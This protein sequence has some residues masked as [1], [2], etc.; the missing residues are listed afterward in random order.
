MNIVAWL[1][2]GLVAGGLAKFIMPGK[3]PGG[4]LTT[5]AIGVLGALLGGFIG[6]RV[7]W[8]GITGFNLSSVGIAIVGAVLLLGLYRLVTGRRSRRRSGSA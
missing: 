3:D 1:A 4:C 2:L 8:G 7:G 5:I 6:T